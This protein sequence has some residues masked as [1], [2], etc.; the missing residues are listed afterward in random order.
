MFNQ[1]KYAL[2]FTPRRPLHHHMDLRPSLFLLFWGAHHL[3]YLHFP[4]SILSKLL[5]LHFYHLLQQLHPLNLLDQNHY[6]NYHHLLNRLIPH[7][8]R[9]HRHP[10]STSSFFHL[11]LIPPPFVHRLI[12]T[13]LAHFY[14]PFLMTFPFLQVPLEVNY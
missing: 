7:Q 3:L 14:P 10:P 11:F 12:F 8:N 5:N 2:L 13:F 1:G 9:P 6:H 4:T